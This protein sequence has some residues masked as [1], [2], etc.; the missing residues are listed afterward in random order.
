MS[1]IFNASI[2]SFD[3]IM[4]FQLIKSRS[5]NYHSTLLSIYFMNTSINQWT[6]R[7]RGGKVHTRCLGRLAVRGFGCLIDLVPENTSGKSSL[8]M[9]LIRVGLG[10]LRE[11]LVKDYNSPGDGFAPEHAKSLTEDTCL[12]WGFQMQIFLANID[13]SEMCLISISK[14]VEPILIQRMQS[15][16]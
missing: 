16:S 3:I 10:L 5:N 11:M 4:E 2:L 9:A 8:A 14:D 15:T 13:G 1:P 7:R 12:F 6:F